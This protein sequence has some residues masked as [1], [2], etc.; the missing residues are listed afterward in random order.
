MKKLAKILKILIIII[1]VVCVALWIVANVLFKL[2]AKDYY[3]ASEKTFSIPDLNSGF[4]PQGLEYVSSDGNFLVTGYMGDGSPSPV[5]VIDQDGNVVSKVSIPDENG[6][7]LTNHNGGISIYGDYVYVAGGKDCEI[8]VYSYKDILNGTP[9]L[10]GTI[11]MRVS[12]DEYLGPAFV[13]ASSGKLI[14]GEF[15]REENYPTCISHQFKTSNGDEHHAIAMVYELGDYPESFGC[16]LESAEVWSIPDLAQG[17]A[18]K[19]GKIYVSESYGTATSTIEVFDYEKALSSDT[20]DI[21]GKTGLKLY[22]LDSASKDNDYI[23]AP[24]AEEITFVGDKLYTM[25]ESASNKYFFGKLTGHFKCYSTDLT[26][27]SN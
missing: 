17:I 11:D 14:I 6:D 8:N 3:N 12:E 10:L 16:N 15:Y 4:I 25:C 24:M 9:E 21:M 23:F 26:K 2:P 19:D 5:H 20:I 27:M 18:F 7:F 22:E 13:T 1:V